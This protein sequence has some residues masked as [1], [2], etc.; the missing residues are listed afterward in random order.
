[1]GIILVMTEVG[2]AMLLFAVDEPLAC[3]TWASGKSIGAL[4]HRFPV[5]TTTSNSG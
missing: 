3:G 1:M 2:V 4:S 5:A